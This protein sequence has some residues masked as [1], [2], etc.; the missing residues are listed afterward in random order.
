MATP[1]LRLPAVIAYTG[2]PRSSIYAKIKAGK[3]P[4]PISLS[5]RTV[6]WLQSEIDAWLTSQIEASRSD[7][8]S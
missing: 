4:S 3:F 8:K 5:S 2:L 6:G 7:D 1:I